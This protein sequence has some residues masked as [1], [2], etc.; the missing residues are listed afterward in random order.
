MITAN[1]ER[2][3]STVQS[4]EESPFWCCSDFKNSSKLSGNKNS[5][6]L[7]F[8]LK[9]LSN[10][11]FDNDQYQL[12]LENS[13][14]SLRQKINSHQLPIDRWLKDPV[15]G[16]VSQNIINIINSGNLASLRQIKFDPVERTSPSNGSIRSLAG[17]VYRGDINTK[18]SSKEL[19]KIYSLSMIS[20][21]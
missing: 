2:Y 10:R 19:L 12:Y 18:Y 5:M 17:Y 11:Y 13:S 15:Q 8:H 20:E 4:D 14:Y 9:G 21:I 1:A 6:R 7:L 3:L 16:S